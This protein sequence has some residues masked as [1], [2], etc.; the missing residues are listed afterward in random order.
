MESRTQ[1]LVFEMRKLY[2]LKIPFCFDFK[3]NYFDK[4]EYNVSVGCCSGQVCIGK[5]LYNFIFYAIRLLNLH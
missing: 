3:F 5:H 2:F 4:Y 1:I